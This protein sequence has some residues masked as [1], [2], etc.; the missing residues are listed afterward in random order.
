MSYCVV[1]KNSQESRIYF[2]DIIK[3]GNIAKIGC[4]GIFVGHKSV[5]Y[6]LRN[7]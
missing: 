1:D 7:V 5:V 4:N 3:R 6:G 2:A